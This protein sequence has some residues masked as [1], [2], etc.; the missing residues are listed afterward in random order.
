MNAITKFITELDEKTERAKGDVISLIK[1]DHR[2][3]DLLF[4]EYATSEKNDDKL[5]LLKN[6]IKEL[7]IHAAAEEKL[8]YP[9][10]KEADSESTNEAYEEHHVVEV[11]LKELMAVQEINELV[12]AKVKVLSELVKHHV[13]EEET[14]LLPEVKK[15]GADLKE[16]GEEFKAEKQRLKTVQLKPGQANTNAKQFKRK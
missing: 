14:T 4:A 16:M 10:L 7:N 3:V 11:V 2:K 1:A 6:I 13:K 5:E 12:D 15:S 9:T 8:V